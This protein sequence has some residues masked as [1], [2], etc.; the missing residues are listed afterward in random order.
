MASERA[1]A[2]ALAEHEAVLGAFLAGISRVAPAR[3]WQPPAAGKWSPAEVA[4]HVTLAYEFGSAAVNAGAAMRPRVPPLGAWLA[5]CVLLPALL[6]VGAF[7]RG[8]A[9]PPEVLP[10]PLEARTLTA[11][12]AARRLAQAGA[13]AARSLCSADARRPAVRVTHAYFGPLA[14]CA[15]LRLLTAHTRHHAQHLVAPPSSA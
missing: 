12:D 11:A 5:R 4:L 7:P 9:S 13:S 2:A 8:A 15:A 1:W 3:W 10:S 6:R 14:P